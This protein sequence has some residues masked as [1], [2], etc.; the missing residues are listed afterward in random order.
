M[1]GYEF[2]RQLRADANLGHLP[3]IFST[4]HYLDQEARALA[5]QCGVPLILPKPSDPETVLGLV[6]AALGLTPSAIP[7]PMEDVFDRDHL[8][9]MTDQLAHKA[10]ELQGLND[11]L[12]ALL[13]LG[14]YLGSEHNPQRLMDAYC[15]GARAIIGAQWSAVGILGND[16]A[17]VYQLFVHGLDEGMIASVGALNASRRVLDTV[18]REHRPC[19]LQNASGAPHLVGLPAQ[20]P[21][22]YSFLGVPIGSQLQ[23]YGWLCLAN[24]LGSDAFSA[25]DE[26]LAVTLATQM[27]VAHENA[28]LFSNIQHQAI[29][30]A[31]EVAERQRSEEVLRS[32]EQ[33]YRDLVEGSIQGMTIYRNFAP[34]FANQAFANIFGYTL[35]EILALDTINKLLAP[36]EHDRVCRYHDAHLRGEDA[37]H[38]YEFQGLRKDG[39]TLWLETMAS[40]VDWEGG[41]AT[42]ATV[43]DITARKRAEAEREQL[44]AQLF[45]A[46]KMEAIGTLAGGIAHDFNNILGIM[47]GYTE[48]TLMDVPHASVVHTR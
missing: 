46:Q 11:K 31:Q 24:K 44:Q 4:A 32:S 37:P 41:P 2:V 25:V 40:L 33:R 21:P 47:L 3:V 19:R 39:S 48:L 15:R 27:A 18:V 5:H 34:L 38:Q 12:T 10:A 45:E 16:Q 30:L 42:Q 7:P 8:R 17:T 13:E 29:E 22:V 20:L 28:Q 1:D 6:D 26:R 35:E 23:V 36:Q 43:V 9:L 14:Q